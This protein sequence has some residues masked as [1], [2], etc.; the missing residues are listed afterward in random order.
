MSAP[1][2]V[3]VVA[4]TAKQTNG[5]EPLRVKHDSNP[6]RVAGALAGVVRQHGKAVIEVIGAGAM[7]QAI[8]ALA[9]ARGFLAPGGVDLRCYPC[10]IDLVIEGQERTG[11]RLVCEPK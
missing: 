8:K 1:T 10:F 9:I 3:S 2:Q 11:M 7:N 6:N 4:A 5:T